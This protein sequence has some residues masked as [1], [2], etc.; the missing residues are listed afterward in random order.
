MNWQELIKSGRFTGAAVIVVVSIVALFGV[1]LS[2]AGLN[3][4]I[5][6][7]VELLAAVGILGGGTLA[8]YVAKE[9]RN[10]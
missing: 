9:K 3:E 4:T 1:E 5:A 10:E 6:K 7:A 2:E 8:G